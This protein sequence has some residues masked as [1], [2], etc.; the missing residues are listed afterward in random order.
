MDSLNA[1]IQR[2]NVKIDDWKA[3]V[4]LLEDRIDT[5]EEQQLEGVEVDAAAEIRSLRERIQAGQG[6]R[7]TLQQRVEE[8]VKKQAEST[9]Q[10]QILQ[11]QLAHSQAALESGATANAAAV[12]ELSVQLAVTQNQLEDASKQQRQTAG[13]QRQVDVLSSQLQREKKLVK[14]W[15]AKASTASASKCGLNMPEAVF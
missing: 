10:L 2:Q 13:L 14:D 9:D 11:A 5:L 1:E 4:S 7:E 3:Q 8:Q 12:D 6:E 15:Q